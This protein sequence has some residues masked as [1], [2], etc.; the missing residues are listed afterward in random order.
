[1]SS[2]VFPVIWFFG[3]GHFDWEEVKNPKGVL[4]GT[5]L[6]A[7]D[8][9]Q[10]KNCLLAVYISSFEDSFSDLLSF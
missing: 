6:V 2:P 10:L 4:I 8:I 3:N 9:E 1:M 7:K 5:F